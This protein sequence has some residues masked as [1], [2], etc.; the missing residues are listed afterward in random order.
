ML[1]YCLF[2]LSEVLATAVALAAR[3]VQLEVAWKL[4]G[5][6]LEVSSKSLGFSWKSLGSH[7]EVTF[8]RLS[9]RCAREADP[10]LSYLFFDCLASN[11]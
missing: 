11:A 9:R 1:F 5:S 4:L 10:P 8:R 2:G 6:G 7:L 3:P